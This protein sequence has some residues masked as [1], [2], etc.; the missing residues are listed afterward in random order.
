VSIFWIQLIP[1][2][3]DALRKQIPALCFVVTTS[4]SLT[5]V[6][7]WSLYFVGTLWQH[8][9]HDISSVETNLSWC[10]LIW[11]ENTDRVPELMV[12]SIGVTLFGVSNSSDQGYCVATGLYQLFVFSL[13]QWWFMWLHL[14]VGNAVWCL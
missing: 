4:S 10:A 1:L 13:A 8:A 5:F 2:K 14:H 11:W 12:L 9:I 3:G 6:A 7:C